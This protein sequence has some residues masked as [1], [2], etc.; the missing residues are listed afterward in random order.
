VW[1]SWFMLG[2]FLAGLAALSVAVFGAVREALRP[3]P[4]A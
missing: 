1:Q 3:P 2:A 4:S